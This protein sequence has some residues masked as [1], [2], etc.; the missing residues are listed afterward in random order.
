MHLDGLGGATGGEGSGHGTACAGII[1]GKTRQVLLYSLPIFDESLT[2][3][4]DAL[5]AALRWS[6]EH[7]MDVVNLSLGT[8]DVVFREA[9]GEVCRQAREA[10]V[11]LVAAEDN[12]GRESY[13]AVLPDVIGVAG[14]RVRGRY[15]YYYR[16]GARIECV[17]RGDVQRVCWTQP[18]YIMASGTSFAAP[19]ITGIVACILS[20]HPG[21]SLERVRQ[22]LQAGAIE[23]DASPK[24]QRRP[25]LPPSRQAAAEPDLGWIRRAALYPFNKEM[26][27]LVRGR[28]LLDFEVVGIAD[29]A[30]KG[31]AGRDAGEA[32]GLP[33]MGVRIQPR[34]LTALK[35]ADTLILGYVDQLSRIGRKDVLIEAVSSALEQGLH[36]FSFAPVPAALHDRAR[37]ERLHIS[38]PAPS[39]AEVQQAL[40]NDPAYPPVDVPVLGVFGTSAQQGKFTLQLGLRRHLLRRGYRLGQVGTE[41]HSALFGMDVVFP[42]GYASTVSLPLETYVPYLDYRMRQLCHQEQPDLILTGSQ[43]GTIPYDVHTETTHSLATTAFLLGTKPDAC[44]LVVNSIDVEAYIQDTIDGIRALTKAPT[45]ALAM[46]D[47][48]KHILAAYGRTL[49]KPRPMA[50]GEISYKLRRLE[51][52]FGLPAVRILSEEGQQHLVDGVIDHFA[53]EG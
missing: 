16:P 5:L 6:I 9:L 30:G 13:P 34:L 25:P 32:L 3:G 31:L 42:M 39:Q 45:L 27:A 28:D 53:T 21:A 22:V 48:E 15:G 1:L 4:G 29:A 36:V 52:R 10:G 24:D 20:E 18:S 7:R 8:T 26:H 37:V 14:G 35:G 17:A 44:I 51:D 23:A 19:H 38:I 50:P 2:A 41:H 12:E 11:I 46:S 47:Q 49:I 33:T 43:S 40:H